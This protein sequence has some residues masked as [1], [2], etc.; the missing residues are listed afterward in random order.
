MKYVDLNG[1][2]K[3]NSGAQ[4]LGDTGDYQ[5]IGNSTPRYNFGLNLDASWKG[6]DLSMFWQG[7]LKRDYW[8]DGPYFWGATG[9][10]WQSAGFVEH[11]DFWRP[12]GDELG[13]NTGAYF[14]RA[15]FDG[16]KNQYV[17]TG[18][19]QDAS[20]IRLKNIQLGYTLP[21]NL[22]KKAGMTSVR[23]YV[24]ADNLLTISDISGMF[25]PEALGG[26]YGA[27]KLYPLQKTISV[28]LN[29]NF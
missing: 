11:W 17:S 18:Y 29:V 10:Q 6:F 28:G 3:I 5:I 14:P 8:L 21:A 23:V 25:D 19:L 15:S 27:G 13:A 7:T 20:Y 12:E 24:S 22:V 9:G 16:G 2:G 4:L 26:D 1:D